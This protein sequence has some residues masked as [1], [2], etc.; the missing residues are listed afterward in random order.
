MGRWF[1]VIGRWF[2]AG[3]AGCAGR[4]AFRGER[5]EHDG[6]RGV[7]AR[8]LGEPVIDQ[9][10]EVIE[11]VQPFQPGAVRSRISV[12]VIF[13]SGPLVRSWEAN[14]PP[15]WKPQNGWCSSSPST[16]SA[17]RASQAR[18]VAMHSAVPIE[19]GGHRRGM[20]GLVE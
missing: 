14:G 15:G 4:A 2:P 11:A 6:G 16:P 5:D 10:E 19:P 3:A 9:D 7:Q 12:A 18:A 1:P 13:A 8:Q 20:V 17:A